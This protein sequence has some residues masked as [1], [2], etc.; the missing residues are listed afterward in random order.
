LLAVL[1]FQL[2]SRGQNLNV[3]AKAW[4]FEDKDN[5]VGREDRSW[6]F[7]AKDNVVGPE[8]K[9]WTFEDKVVGPEDKS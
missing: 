9:A 4:T 2:C 3:K 7:E 8:V 1:K 6:T 5:V